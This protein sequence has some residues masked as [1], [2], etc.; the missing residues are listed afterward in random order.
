[1]TKQGETPLTSHSVGRCVKAST[2]WP[3]IEGDP[4][5]KLWRH[6][7]VAARVQVRNAMHP[8]CMFGRH[9]GEDTMWQRK[10]QSTAVQADV[11]RTSTSTP[12]G[13]S[14][15]MRRSMVEEDRSFTSISRWCR[16]TW[17]RRQGRSSEGGY[18]E[19][20]EQP[21]QGART[22]AQRARAQPRT[23]A[24]STPPAGRHR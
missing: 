23:G 14:R 10:R 19:H 7:G 15:V 1:M 13:R 4:A 22:G 16:R 21:R 9:C 8:C 6:A 17:G 24:T 18:A 20:A 11:E 12:A 5:L 2:S 3:L